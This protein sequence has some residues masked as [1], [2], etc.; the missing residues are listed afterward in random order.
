M[1]ISQGEL[2]IKPKNINIDLKLKMFTDGA[3]RGNPGPGGYGTILVWG[4][5]VKELSGGY[6]LTTNNRMEL[7]A[8]I[9]GLES[10]TRDGLEV[11]VYSDSKYVCEAVE[12]GWIWNWIKT[13]FKGKKNADL[14]MQFAELYRKHKV[15]FI[16]IK[17]HAGHPEN[18]RCDRLATQAADN[19]A[20][21]ADTGY[22]MSLNSN[23]KDNLF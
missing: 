13:G 12:K 1:L 22:L 18:E 2:K 17:G 4:S 23:E 19:A 5:H 9:A 7:R 8:V 10:L 3:A 16:W 21:Q 15:K 11:E 6:K 14:W 20:I